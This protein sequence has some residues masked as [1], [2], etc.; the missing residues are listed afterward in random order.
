MV[1]QLYLDPNEEE[2]SVIAHSPA[3]KSIWLAANPVVSLEKI[4]LV[5]FEKSTAG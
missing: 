2:N 1:A 4:C 5:V 3:L